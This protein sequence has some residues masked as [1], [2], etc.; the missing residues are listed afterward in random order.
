MEPRAQRPRYRFG[1]LTLDEGR[2]R[3]S[4]GRTTIELGKL[5]YEMLRVLVKA[6]PNVL[7]HDEFAEGVW[8]SRLVTP[9]TVTQRV[10]LLRDALGDDARSPR[11]IGLVRG[12]GYRL[13]PHVRV[14]DAVEHG[15]QFV[16]VLPFENLSRDPE[17][18][19]FAV[20][21][22]EEILTQL[23]RVPDLQVLARTSVRWYEDVRRPITEIAAELGVGSVMEGSI[24][25]EENRVRITAQLID[26]ASGAHLWA[27]SFEHERSD[28][29][30]IQDDVADR[31]STAVSGQCSYGTD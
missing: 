22:H 4:R 11:Y 25:Y 19:Y 3:V 29:F 30:A 8:A 24:R 13:L 9:E 14:M 1:D 17:D 20:G 27:E 21:V 26:G 7:T 10:K 28:S 15:R 16:A 6:A 18:G 2:R 23:A 5:T 31:I 12:Q